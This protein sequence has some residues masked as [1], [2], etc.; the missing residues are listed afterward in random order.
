MTK[1]TKPTSDK[2]AKPASIP[3]TQKQ[4]MALFGITQM[5]AYHWRHR[6][7]SGRPVIPHK[8][9]GRNVTYPSGQVI[10]WATKHEVPIA[11]PLD[12]VLKMGL[13]NRGSGRPAKSA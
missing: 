7:V 3:L 13:E 5:T 4:V 2:P 8:L 11:K 12:K 1:Q 10:N 6:E 9:N